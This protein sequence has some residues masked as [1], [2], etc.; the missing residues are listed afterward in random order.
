MTLT[1]LGFQDRD[2]TEDNP[3]V[4]HRDSSKIILEFRKLVFGDLSSY[5]YSS[6]W[7]YLLGILYLQKNICFVPRSLPSL[8]EGTHSLVK[9][10]EA[11]EPASAAA[12]G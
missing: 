2:V 5:F 8:S 12:F 6:W 11:I 9:S 1:L 3:R 7:F 4:E 10:R